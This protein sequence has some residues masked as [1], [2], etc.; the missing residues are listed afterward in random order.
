[1]NTKTNPDLQWGLIAAL[2]AVGLIRPLM[3]VL[4][5]YQAFPG[6]GTLLLVNLFVAALWVRVVVARR[7][8]NPVATLTLVGGLHAIFVI[9][10]QQ[11]LS[12]FASWHPLPSVAYL[13]IL[14]TNLFWG[15]V[16]GLV[17]AALTRS[18]TFPRRRP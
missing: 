6:L 11:I 12:S 1:M 13:S 9:L 5:V 4:G 17:A 3:G 2:A 8:P 18:A 15:A 7:L 16:L 14:L 10:L